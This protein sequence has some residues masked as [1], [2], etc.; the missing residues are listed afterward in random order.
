ME[1][2]GA[3]IAIYGATGFTG[4]LLVAELARRGRPLVLSGRDRP[5]LEVLAAGVDDAR[6]VPAAL[7]D[8]AGVRAALDGCGAVVNCA[9]PFARLG[10]PVVAAALAAGV[11]YLDTSGEARWMHHVLDDHG[12]AAERR[13]IALLPAAGFD[14]VPGDLACALAARGHEPLR[15]L[16]VAY[17][18]A[19]G[20]FTRGTMRSAVG[21]LARPELVWEDGEL[22]AAP[23]RPLRRQ[24]TFPAPIGRRIVTRFPG[25]EPVTVPRHV[26]VRRLEVVIDARAFAL[27]ADPVAP[28]IPLA[29]PVLRPLLRG[30]VLG[31]LD[32]AIGALPEGP[33]QERRARTRWTLVA[34]G[35]GEDG[36]R[37]EAVVQGGDVYG[38]TA[39]I[40]A[41]LA[42]RAA[43]GELPAGGLSPAQ[44]ADPAGFLD[45]LAH[46]GVQWR[47]GAR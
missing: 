1:P 24:V 47:A 37:T 5:R 23:W 35:H 46:H 14:Y 4:R 44:A 6:A 29:T 3:P 12:P 34:R 10:E 43:D 8:P 45:A 16:L 2:S 31:G 28:L 15:S 40:A 33:S 18:V 9:G 7:D 39:V 42:T 32:A 26:R 13:G 21:L 11:P 19:G 27:G 25:G 36:A 41:T 30:P 38:L 20:G 22:R 17:A